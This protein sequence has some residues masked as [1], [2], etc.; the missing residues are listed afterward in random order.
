MGE[1]SQKLC[2]RPTLSNR[3][4]DPVSFRVQAAPDI[5]S[6]E[7][8]EEGY[9]PPHNQFVDFSSHCNI[10]ELSVTTHTPF[11]KEQECSWQDDSAGKEG[12]CEHLGFAVMN[13]C[14][15]NIHECVF[16]GQVTARCIGA[17]WIN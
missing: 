17:L 13:K 10:R 2:C 5:S 14:V 15:M 4:V 11:K 7:A 6:S 3:F 16:S 8:I 12:C 1:S 9:S